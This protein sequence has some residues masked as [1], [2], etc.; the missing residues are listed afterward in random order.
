M[1]RIVVVGGNDMFFQLFS[2]NLTELKIESAISR[3]HVRLKAS[4]FIIGE[5]WNGREGDREIGVYGR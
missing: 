1:Y 5:E 2:I 3:E 4:A